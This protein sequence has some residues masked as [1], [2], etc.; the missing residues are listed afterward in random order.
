MADIVNRIPYELSNFGTEGGGSYSLKDYRFDYAL[1]GI[2]F[3]SATRDQWP[4]TEGMAE[5]RKQQFDSFA[6]PGEQSLYGWWLRSQSTFNAGAGLLYQDPDNDNQFNYR[7]QDSL[8]VDPWNSGS[9]ALLRIMNQ[10]VPNPLIGSSVRVRGYVRSNGTD[11]AYLVDGGNLYDIDSAGSTGVVFASVG[12]LLDLANAGNR[13]LINMTDGVWSNVESAAAT[14][15]F[16]FPITPTTGAV[17]YV[18]GRVCVTADNLLYLAPVNTGGTLA[19]D[20]NNQFKFV[21]PDPTFKWTS[22]TEGPSGI[23]AAGYNTTQSTVYKI[24]I[25]FSGGTEVFLPTVTCT[26]PTGELISDVYVYVGSYMG[27]ATNKGFRVG[28]FNTY[29]GDVVYGPLLFQPSGGCRGVVGFDRFLY[30][31]S[32]NAHDG[33]SGVYR[34]DLGTQVQEQTTKAVRYA[35]SRDAYAS[36]KSG[37]IQSVSML[38]ASNRLIFPITQDSIMLQSSSTLVP[39]GY[40]KTGRIRYNTEEPKLYKFVSLR[41]PHTLDGDVAFSLIDESGAET[42]Y[43]TYGPTFSTNTG[44]VSTPTPAGRQNW[45][46]LKFTLS[47]GSDTTKGGVLNGWQVKALPGSTRQRLISHTWLLFDEEMDKG[48]QRMGGDGYARQRF[49]DFKNLAKTGDVVVFQELV[50]DISTLVIID[51]WKFTQLGPPGPNA[52]TLGGY[53]TVVLRTIAEAT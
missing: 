2:P 49:E 46:Q 13:S 10:H 30:V 9:L 32:T 51:D 1:G 53:L 42:P 4:Y 50:E 25:D 3:L 35:F 33:Q 28:E 24:T 37:S 43:I 41:T 27:I 20:T 22:V 21:H 18:K 31:G 17:E 39:S 23:Y 45:I 6:E 47:R 16:S 29:T 7:F 40:L 12:S 44:D 34:V 26:M 11:A 36:G 19:I 48:G 52:S 8:G 38:G 15:M 5:I 14:K